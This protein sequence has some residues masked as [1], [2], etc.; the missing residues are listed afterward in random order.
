MTEP[1]YSVSEIDRLRKATRDL[2][3]YYYAFY[4]SS[5]GNGRSYSVSNPQPDRIE[6]ILRTYML[7]GTSVSELEAAAQAHINRQTQRS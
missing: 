6:D 4:P 1:R 3:S 5:S 7:N 2:H